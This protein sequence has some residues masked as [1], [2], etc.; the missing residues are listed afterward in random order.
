MKRK[1]E[2]KASHLD[3]PLRFE[4]DPAVIFVLDS[5]FRLTYCNAAWNRFALENG[6]S[7]QVLRE[8]QIGRSVMEAT[9]EPLKRFYS[10]LYAKVLFDEPS[11]D[12]LYECSSAET[13]R[14]F[15]MGIQRIEISEHD[16]FLV[17]VN[18][19]LLEEPP[20]QSAAGY[21]PE[22]MREKNG[23]IT[24]CAHCRRTRMPES[25]GWVWAPELIRH[26]PMD[27]S[28]GLCPVCWEIHY[29]SSEI[30]AAS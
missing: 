19:L 12:H 8:R 24:M 4:S 2:D 13:F 9:P 6:G 7:P 18:S 3:W 29:G 22:A 20:Q 26:M 25:G 28:H 27:V 14:R 17:V 11:S 30:T 23:L 1:P 15:H 16:P 5:D 10:S 21:D